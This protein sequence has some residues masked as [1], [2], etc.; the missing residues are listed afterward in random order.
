MWGKQIYSNVTYGPWAFLFTGIL[1]Y[2]IAW[3]CWNGVDLINKSNEIQP[4]SL[5]WTIYVL[6]LTLGILFGFGAGFLLLMP[7]VAIIH[8]FF[9][10]AGYENRKGLAR[11]SLVAMAGFI[12]LGL[13]TVILSAFKANAIVMFKGVDPFIYFFF[14]LALGWYGS[15]KISVFNDK[16]V[17]EIERFTVKD[18]HDKEWTV[19][20]FQELLKRYTYGDLSD[21]ESSPVNLRRIP[22]RKYLRTIEGWKVIQNDKVIDNIDDKA[23]YFYEIYDFD[24]WGGETLVMGEPT[25]GKIKH[26]TIG[27]TRVVELGLQKHGNRNI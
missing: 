22:L 3:N 19:V 13:S 14:A 5:F 2:I 17:V 8:P 7:M 25:G 27:A 24:Y 16:E 20:E 10:I 12:W 6:G 23:Y 18:E 9:E 26:H 4:A 1:L 11:T 15:L 21:G